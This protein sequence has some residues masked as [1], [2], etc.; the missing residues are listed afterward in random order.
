M[1]AT[2]LR[3]SAASR[4]RALAD[5]VERPQAPTADRPSAP[6]VEPRRPFAPLVRL[7][8]QWW[9]RGEILDPSSPAEPSPDVQLLS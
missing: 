8:G 3:H 4:L 7:G 6:P 2:T 5:R 9:Y 1:P